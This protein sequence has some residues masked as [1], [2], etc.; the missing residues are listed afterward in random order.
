MANATSNLDRITIGKE[1]YIF[2]LPVEGGE[3]IYEGTLVSQL[4]A[5]GCVV[6]YSTAS[7]EHAVGVAQH[8]Q[9]NTSGADADKRVRVESGRMFAFTNG[10][11]ADAFADTDFIGAPVYASDDHTVAKT[12]DTNARKP[13][14][15][16]Y[17]F[18]ADGKV[19]VFVDPAL[20]RLYAAI[21]A[22][23]DSP[24][25]VDALRDNLVSKAAV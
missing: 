11:S 4:T 7:S 10:A 20:A 3:H 17:G 25:S 9:D 12:S 19:R 1:G 16:F 5:S 24:A 15:F 23:T 21:A 8:E 14:G 13:V 6:P 22:L 18:E 2:D